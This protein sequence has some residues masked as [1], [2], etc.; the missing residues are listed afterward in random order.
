MKMSS[1]ECPTCSRRDFDS[2]R[3]MKLHH[4]SAHG[5]SLSNRAE[6]EFNCEWCG[7]LFIREV[8]PE[9]SRRFCS[10]SCAAK[11][12]HS[13]EGSQNQGDESARN[14]A[15]KRDGGKCQRCGCEVES[16]HRK[17]QQSAEVHHLIPKAAGGPDAITNLVTLCLRCHM[18]AH[19]D[20]RD[21]H[22]SNPKLLEKLC[23][24]VCENE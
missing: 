13:G 18:E 7:A 23:E 20:M 17:T 10:R 4:T 8:N 6:R 11:H 15:L 19:R 3:A 21:I 5:Q 14:K 22:E 16:G 9:D 2:K 1:I 12:Q 24:V